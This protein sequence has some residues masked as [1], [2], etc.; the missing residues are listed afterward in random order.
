MFVNFSVGSEGDVELDTVGWLS[1]RGGAG[2]ISN[3]CFTARES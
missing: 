2:L 3:F 1:F